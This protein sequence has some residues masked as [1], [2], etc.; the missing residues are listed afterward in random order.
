VRLDE[1]VHPFQVRHCLCPQFVLVPLH[2]LGHQ[3]H[4]VLQR[5]LAHGRGHGDPVVIVI[6]I[7]PVLVLVIVVLVLVLVVVD[8][9][10]ATFNS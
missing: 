2:P 4:D 5:C 7:V 8:Q 3:C 1:D 6:V 9:L 10:S